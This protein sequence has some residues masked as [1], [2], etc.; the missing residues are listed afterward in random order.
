ML[1]V[2]TS[3]GGSKRPR[4]RSPRRAGRK[5]LASEAIGGVLVDSTMLFE[6]GYE[7]HNTWACG[8]P[9]TI[10]ILHVIRMTK[11]DLLLC[12]LRL[13]CTCVATLKDFMHLIKA[14]WT[15][16]YK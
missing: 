14:I 16:G 2:G 5:F 6:M 8:L 15:H 7:E 4:T 1:T 3:Q 11:A 13:W 12:V 9:I 10:S